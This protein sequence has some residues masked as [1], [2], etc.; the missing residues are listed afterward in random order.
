MWASNLWLLS[1][2]KSV[3]NLWIILFFWKQHFIS[4][5]LSANSMPPKAVSDMLCLITVK[6][7][8]LIQTMGIRPILQTVCSEIHH[9][10]SWSE[11]T[12]IKS[13]FDKSLTVFI[14]LHNT[15]EKVSDLYL[16][17]CIGFGQS[18]LTHF[19]F[20]FVSCHKYTE[21]MQPEERNMSFLKCWSLIDCWLIRCTQA[22]LCLVL[23]EMYYDDSL[24]GYH[25]YLPVSHC[26][27][28]KLSDNFFLMQHIYTF[29]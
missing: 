10:S 18:P 19:S 16:V 23:R 13:T 14:L 29:A 28:F 11:K 2:T 17:P 15:L 20:S 26:N 21:S 8:S 7:E 1:V 22:C 4:L 3:L 27:S 5:T 25:H 9:A 6:D 24:S 12:N